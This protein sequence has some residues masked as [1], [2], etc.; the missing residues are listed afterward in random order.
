M[1]IKK[2]SFLDYSIT[3]FLGQPVL[4]L[5]FFLVIWNVNFKT[6]NH[7]FPLN[8]FVSKFYIFIRNSAFFSFR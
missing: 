8:I 6:L 2:T 4:E 1:Q 7:I 5:F 3:K